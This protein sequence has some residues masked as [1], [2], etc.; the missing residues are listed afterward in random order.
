MA[1]GAIERAADLARDAERASVLLGN[2]DALD[3]RALV[4]RMGGRHPEQPF[5]GAVGRDLFGDDFGPHE[6]IARRKRLQER[7]RDVAHRRKL[8]RAA[9][10]NPVPELRDAHVALALGDADFGKGAGKLGARRA[11]EAHGRAAVGSGDGGVHG[12]GF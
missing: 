10:V 11:G 1:E 6:A 12:A 7:P 3:F 2:I 8:A 5:A 9:V 4:V